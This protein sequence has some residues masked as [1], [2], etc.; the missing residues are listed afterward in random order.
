MV[1]ESDWVSVTMVSV[2]A[3]CCAW[4]ESNV[5]KK[6][7]LNLTILVG[8][9]YLKPP[10]SNSPTCV[11]DTHCEWRKQSIRYS[12][13]S[14]LV[15]MTNFFKNFMNKVFRRRKLD[16]EGLYS[17]PDVSNPSHASPVSLN[18]NISKSTIPLAVSNQSQ[19]TLLNPR[20]AESLRSSAPSR[21]DTANKVSIEKADRPR[22]EECSTSL[23][24]SQQPVL[25]K[26]GSVAWK[27]LETALRLLERS[28]DAFP[29]LKSA[30]G[31]L[32]ACLDVA[33]VNYC[34]DFIDVVF[35][36]VIRQLSRIVKSMKISQMN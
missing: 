6:E 29:P 20:T 32:V 8:P 17:S 13:S 15:N 26:A 19:D 2:G 4:C 31:G 3:Q 21:V 27:G 10:Q 1:S 22:S 7:T 16:A 28:A 23:R 25:V 18:D 36:V 30:I 33:Q 14:R 24:P 12:S 5:T 34:L 11:L 35:E 9:A